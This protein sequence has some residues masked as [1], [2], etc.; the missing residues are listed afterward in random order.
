M[1]REET[2][3]E[4]LIALFQAKPSDHTYLDS[5]RVGAAIEPVNLV[6]G[7]IHR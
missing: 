7:L 6:F 3:L 2:Y 4:S 5:I 1:V